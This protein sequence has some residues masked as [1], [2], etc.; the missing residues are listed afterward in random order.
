MINT[1]NIFIL[2]P[3]TQAEYALYGSTQEKEL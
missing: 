1:R 2:M 3:Y